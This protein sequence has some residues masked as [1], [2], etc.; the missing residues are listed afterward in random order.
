[1]QAIHSKW[2][3]DLHHVQ[4]ASGQVYWMVCVQKDS[5]LNST[6][7]EGSRQGLL[8]VAGRRA[9]HKTLGNRWVCQSA[10]EV[11]LPASRSGKSRE[12]VTKTGLQPFLTSSHQSPKL[13]RRAPCFRLPL[14]GLNQRGLLN[15]AATTRTPDISS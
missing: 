11:P 7:S 15:K 6:D 4:L 13:L 12:T 3:A 2:T 1:M 14:L 8:V 9:S 10:P 5:Q